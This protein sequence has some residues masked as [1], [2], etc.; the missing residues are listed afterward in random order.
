MRSQ[1]EIE[2]AICEGISRFE[3]DYMGRGPKDIHAHLIGDLLVV[4][5]HGVLTADLWPLVVQALPGTLL[6]SWLGARVYR[7]LPEP[8]GANAAGVRR[9]GCTS[10]LAGPPR[11]AGANRRWSTGD[12][13]RPT[14]VSL[15]R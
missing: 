5:L 10:G 9:P 6:G 11:P 2:A 7:R 12:V 13:Q 14:A 4:R 1:G 15:H 8:V 3:Q